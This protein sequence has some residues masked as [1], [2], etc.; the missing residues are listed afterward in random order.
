MLSKKLSCLVKN[1]VGINHLLTNYLE[2]IKLLPSPPRYWGTEESGDRRWGLHVGGVCWC[3]Q[4]RSTSLVKKKKDVKINSL[5]YYSKWSNN[6]MKRFK[7]ITDCIHNPRPRASAAAER[8]WS[9]EKQTSSVD[10]A[11][12][13]LQDFRCILLRYFSFFFLLFY[14]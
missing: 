1:K 10:K 4:P 12:P 7:I 8:L 2:L 5:S 13:R 6:P 3:H 11:F 14:I 9:N